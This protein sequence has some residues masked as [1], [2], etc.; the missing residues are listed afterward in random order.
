MMRFMII[1]LHIV[2]V[3]LLVNN[4][5]AFQIEG[6]HQIVQDNLDSSIAFFNK[7][8]ELQNLPSSLQIPKCLNSAK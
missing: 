7:L 8:F 4:V 2:A 3:I 6:T 1:S 5:S